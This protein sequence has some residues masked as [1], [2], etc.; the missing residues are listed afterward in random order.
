MLGFLG[1]LSISAPIAGFAV[2][3]LGEYW[4]VWV[5]STVMTAAAAVIMW[6]DSTGRTPDE[7]V[8]TTTDAPE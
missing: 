1:G 2:D 6:F 7:G 4:P 5:A 3:R 8:T